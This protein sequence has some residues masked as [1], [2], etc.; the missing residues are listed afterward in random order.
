MSL[1]N[2]ISQ[3]QERTN[4]ASE[5]RITILSS[6]GRQRAVH[7]CRAG[8]I[9]QPEYRRYSNHTWLNADNRNIFLLFD[10]IGSLTK[11][12]ARARHLRRNIFFAL[13]GPPDPSGP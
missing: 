11:Y 7:A 4:M 8:G 2:E 9:A 6:G 1:F 5:R 13:C 3:H 10:N 12:S